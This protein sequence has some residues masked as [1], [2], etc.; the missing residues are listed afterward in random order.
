[1]VALDT[2]GDGEL[3]AKEIE[4]TG[5]ALKTLDKGENDEAISAND[6]RVRTQPTDLYSRWLFPL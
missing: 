6:C 5:K 2:D 1:M 4:N 3:S